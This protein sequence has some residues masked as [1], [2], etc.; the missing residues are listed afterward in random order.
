[1]EV[2]LSLALTTALLLGS[3]GPAPLAL[4]GVGA[5]FGF[6]Q[7]SGFLA[8]ILGGL[9]VVIAI[10][11]AGLGTLFNAYPTIKIVCQLAAAGYLCFVAYRIATAQGGITSQTGQPPVFKDGFILNLI[12]PKAYA[13]FLAIFANNMLQTHSPL[14]NLLLTATVCFLVAVIVDTLWMA[15]G[16]KLR[17]FF[18]KPKQAKRLR[19]V[20][21]LALVVSVMVAVVG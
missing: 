16:A 12:N 14:L 20:F 1:M 9:L 10:V 11:A 4:A 13:A 21:A 2:V 18:A 3:P 5:S 8:G 7:G 15:A 17:V 6:R 19:L